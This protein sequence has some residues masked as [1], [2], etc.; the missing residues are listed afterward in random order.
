MTCKSLT[1]AIERRWLTISVLMLAGL[2]P[3]A[4]HAGIVTLTLQ[5]AGS[6]NQL[7]LQNQPGQAGDDISAI[8]FLVALEAS[9]SADEELRDMLREGRAAAWR[10]QQIDAHSWDQPMGGPSADRYTWR[11]FTGKAFDEAFALTDS[12]YG[13]FVDYGRYDD[14]Y[15]IEDPEVAPVAPGDELGGFFFNPSVVFTRFLVAGVVDPWVFAGPVDLSDPPPDLSAMLG[16]E[17]SIGTVQFVPEPSCLMLADLGGIGLL[18]C[19]RR[20]AKR[21]WRT[22]VIR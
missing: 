16:I 22:L 21:P 6:L 17:T 15:V 14:Q 19:L 3:T 13:F 7:V 8:A 18:V 11:Q 1:A 20:R 12:C 9:A 5:S 2:L 10:V 4:A